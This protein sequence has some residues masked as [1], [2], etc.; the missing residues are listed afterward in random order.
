MYDTEG[1]VVAAQVELL[2]RMKL[3]FIKKQKDFAAAEARYIS[4]RACT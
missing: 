4:C 2:N 3:M 1:A